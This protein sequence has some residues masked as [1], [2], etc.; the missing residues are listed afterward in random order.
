MQ[1]EGQGRVRRKRRGARLLRM[2]LEPRFRE[3]HGQPHGGRA[4]ISGVDGEPSGAIAE[5]F[6]RRLPGWRSRTDDFGRGG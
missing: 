3:G 5:E 1:F 6:G 2:G 4:M